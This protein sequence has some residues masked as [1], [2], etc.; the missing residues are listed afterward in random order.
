MKCNIDAAM[1]VCVQDMC[2]MEEEGVIVCD[3]FFAFIAVVCA[4][5]MVLLFR[6][7]ESGKGLLSSTCFIEGIL[8]GAGTLTWNT[9]FFIEFF[10]YSCM[11]CLLVLGLLLFKKNAITAKY[12]NMADREGSMDMRS[13]ELE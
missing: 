11:V 5:Y 4:C 7:D 13:S 2:Y 8:G 3:Y 12:E 6:R 10:T 9:T 1:S